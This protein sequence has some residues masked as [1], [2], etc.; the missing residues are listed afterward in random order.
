LNQGAFH[1][2]MNL[3]A[4]YNLPVIFVLENNGYSMGTHI[5]RGTAMADAMHEKAEGHG[6]RYAECDGLDV[7]DV[8]R[9]F[10]E[11]VA[12]TRG[13]QNPQWERGHIPEYH[14][15]GSNPGPAFINV[16]TYR[17][18][19]HSMSDPQKYRSKDEVGEFE[20]KDCINRLV[21]YLIEHDAATQE[22]IDDLDKKA[23][24]SAKAA[25]KFAEESPEMPVDEMFTD[26]YLDH[27]NKEK[28]PVG[29]PA[30]GFR[31]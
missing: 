14:K 17:Y 6:M 20:N 31:D 1:E 24:E 19:G 4:I 25:I 21:R 30:E 23:K 2:S 15:D 10:S 8:Y 7:L 26:I 29:Q 13:A 12:M 16:V 28:F 9:T 3:A 27:P 11:Q 22:Q 5:A 18:Q